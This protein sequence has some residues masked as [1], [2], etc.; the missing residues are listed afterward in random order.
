MRR[1][2]DEG[3]EQRYQEDDE[4]EGEEEEEEE[5]EE[6]EEGTWERERPPTRSWE[7]AMRASPS[8]K[9]S[10]ITHPVPHPS[11]QL[12]PFASKRQLR[13]PVP[14]AWPPPVPAS[15]LHPHPNY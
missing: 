13:S 2:E 15:T 10:A 8:K 5:E 4:E 3:R 12:C 1:K 9:S 14:S 7:R 6:H 11:H